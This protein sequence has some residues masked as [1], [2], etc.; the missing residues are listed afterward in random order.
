VI[1]GRFER[2]FAWIARPDSLMEQSSMALAVD[3]RAWLVDPVKMPDVE[4]AIEALGKPAGIIMTLGWHDRDVDWYAARYGV[5][6]YA[7]SHLNAVLVKSR[8]ERVPEGRTVPGTPFRL[9]D[10]SAR[11]WMK[12]WTESVLWWPEEGVLATGDC[13]GTASY[14]V[15]PGARLGVHPLRRLSPPAEL[16]G[17]APRRIYCGHGP[18]VQDGAGEA[19]AAAL[20]GAARDLLGGWLASGRAAVSRLRGTGGPSRSRPA[21]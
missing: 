1:H 6:V 3:G 12:A 9:L 17:L 4:P 15:R 21:L 13:L 5:P 19:L 2:G 11:R 7:A 8:V 10:A 16:R 14:F 18:S 20:D